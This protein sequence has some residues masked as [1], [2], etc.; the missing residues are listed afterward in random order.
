MR[1]VSDNFGNYRL[2]SNRLIYEESDRKPLEEL[3]QRMKG[4]AEMF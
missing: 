1:E 3:R 4:V 2:V